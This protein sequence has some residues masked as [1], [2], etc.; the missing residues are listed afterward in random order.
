MTPMQPGNSIS[1]EQSQVSAS[2]DELFDAEALVRD[3]DERLKDLT[4]EH[5]DEHP[6]D[7]ELDEDVD[8]FLAAIR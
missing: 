2:A 1:S 5:A 8:R 6:T 3:L 4:F 7:S